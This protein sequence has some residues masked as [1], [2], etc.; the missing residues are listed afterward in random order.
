ME[1]TLVAP[2]LHSSKGIVGLW[3][4][5]GRPQGLYSGLPKPFVEFI[6]SLSGIHFWRDDKISKPLSFS[7]GWVAPVQ[8]A[9][10]FA[11]TQGALHLIGARLT[12]GAAASLFGPV[13]NCDAGPPVPLQDLM[14]RQASLL[15]EQLLELR[16]EAQR[17]ACLGRWIATRLKGE[18]ALALPTVETLADMGWRADALADHLGLS[19]RGLH[20][21][22]KERLGIGPKFWLQ[23][24]RFDSLLRADVTGMRLAET[25]T[26]FG[27]TDQSHMTSDFKRFA[28]R[29][30]LDYLKTRR[31]NMAPD[32]APHF[33]PNSK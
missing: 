27:Y 3:S 24:H 5:R 25:A 32:A 8:A 6:V 14:G 18:P 7:D 28:G 21:R 23:L 31:E 26:A 12:V 33:L 11:E 2:R 9:P 30:P 10:R 4:L 19:P 20:K 17:M 16:T 15:R 22:F 1:M 29:S 13:L